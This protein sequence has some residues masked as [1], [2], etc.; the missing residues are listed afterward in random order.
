MDSQHKM[1]SDTIKWQIEERMKHAHSSYSEFRMLVCS[2]K[3]DVFW[4]VWS[5]YF[6]NIWEKSLPSHYASY[7]YLPSKSVSEDCFE[8]VIH[9]FDDWFEKHYLILTSGLLV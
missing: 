2:K 1:F 8:M 6:F 9:H 3:K 7:L 5:K 4:E